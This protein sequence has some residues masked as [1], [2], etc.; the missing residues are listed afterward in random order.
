MDKEMVIML[1]Q[2][3]TSS[4]TYFLSGHCVRAVRAVVASVPLSPSPVRIAQRIVDRRSPPTAA[5]QHRL[6]HFGISNLYQIK[7]VY[8]TAGARSND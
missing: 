3:P 1:N 6:N 4:S 5:P 7:L 2:G 8:G